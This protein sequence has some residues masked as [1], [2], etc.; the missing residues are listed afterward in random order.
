MRR[1]RAHEGA[2]GRGA[3][4]IFG[5]GK[6]VGALIGRSFIDGNNGHD[7][8]CAGWGQAGAHESCVERGGWWLILVGS[9]EAGPRSAAELKEAA[10]HYHLF[11]RF[12]VTPLVITLPQPLDLVKRELRTGNKMVTRE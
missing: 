11:N 10:T 12:G 6:G 1:G 9:W 8:A 4:F 3:Y 2:A 5:G 7:Q